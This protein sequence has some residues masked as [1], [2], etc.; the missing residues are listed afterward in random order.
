MST[1]WSA[2]FGK[3]CTM[4]LRSQSEWMHCVMCFWEIGVSGGLAKKNTRPSHGMWWTRNYV[5]RVDLSVAFLWWRRRGYLTV[6]IH[7]GFVPRQSQVCGCVAA[8][9]ISV[10]C[11]LSI[12]FQ[13]V[14]NWHAWPSSKVELYS[15]KSGHQAVLRKL[16]SSSAGMFVIQKNDAAL[17]R[18]SEILDRWHTIYCL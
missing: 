15:K 12:M 7:D 11:L 18:K 10:R 9:S 3:V 5:W 4:T 1:P 16:C 8:I 17:K 2:G 6:F 14:Y 13:S